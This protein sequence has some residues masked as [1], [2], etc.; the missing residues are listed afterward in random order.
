MALGVQ[1]RRGVRYL[2][3]VIALSGCWPDEDVVLLDERFEE[4]WAER[5]VLSGSATQ[6]ETVHPG[7]HGVVFLAPT[8]MSVPLSITTYDQY[9]DGLWLEYSSTCGGSPVFTSQ[10]EGT[11]WRLWLDLPMSDFDLRGVGVYGRVHLNLPPI[12]MDDPW[13][14]PVEQT[15]VG[16]S[17]ATAGAPSTLCVLDNLRIVEPSVEYGF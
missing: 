1:C 9:T 3:L 11:G 17:V 5:W 6:V 4:G 12:F 15:I 2:V 14:T 7:E 13:G 10:R 8:T 16:L